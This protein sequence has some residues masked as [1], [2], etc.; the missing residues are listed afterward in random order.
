MHS[1]KFGT[2]YARHNEK[3]QETVYVGEKF[4]KSSGFERVKVLKINGIRLDV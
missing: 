3:I 1:K 2:L 4:D